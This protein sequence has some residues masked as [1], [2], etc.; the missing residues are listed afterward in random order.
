MNPTEDV[1]LKIPVVQE[2]S[3]PEWVR[4]LNAQMIQLWWDSPCGLPVFRNTYEAREQERREQRLT[5]LVD[6][7]IQAVRRMPE[8][9]PGR[10]SLRKR[11][12]DQAKALAVDA[13]GLEAADLDFLESSGLVQASQEFARMARRFDPAVSGEDIYQAGRNAFSTHLIQLLMGL[14]VA[15]TPPVFAY[16][17]LYPYT[18]NYLD[19]PLIPG[20]VKRDFNARFLLRLRGEPFR[21]VNRHEEIISE[22]VSMIEGDFERARFP[23]VWDSLAAIH[24]AQARSLNLMALGA[25]PY[26]SDVLGISFEKGGAAVLADGYLAAGWV[27]PEEAAFLYGYGVFTQLMD[28][29]EDL[30]SDRRAGRL[31]IF[32]QTAPHWKLDAITNRVIHFGRSVFDLA[33]VFQSP[34]AAPLL[35]L[36]GR[37]LDTALLSLVG[38]ASRYYSPA[39]RRKVESSMPFHFA[40]LQKQYAK[41]E[42]RHISLG[43]WVDSWLL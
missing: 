14:P 37:G 40:A 20:A 39:Y 21:P 31:T 43:G 13:L 8:D 18:D 41:L 33:R 5:G 34:G 30:E 11:L 42:R 9:E 25:S 10:A 22:L 12:G 6:E 7:V 19:D 36:I 29:L 1:E 4:D 27:A 28:D 26:E 17:M 35:H 15:V 38:R 2:I 32:S 24:S 3:M 16:S 23:L